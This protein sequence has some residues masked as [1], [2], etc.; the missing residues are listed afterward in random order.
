MRGLKVGPS[1]L[2][3]GVTLHLLRGRHQRGL[4]LA[5]PRCCGRRLGVRGALCCRGP[6]L[7]AL[8]EGQGVLAVDDVD[9]G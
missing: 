3:H 2:F 1:A 4:A 7:L 6:P 5:A 9:P 8:Q